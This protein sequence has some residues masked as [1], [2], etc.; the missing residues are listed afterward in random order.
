MMNLSE[1]A[2]GI[3]KTMNQGMKFKT[4]TCPCCLHPWRIFCGHRPLSD[5]ARIIS[6]CHGHLATKEFR[7]LTI[8]LDTFMYS[9][10]LYDF[11][12]NHL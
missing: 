1:I 7:T 6:A 10:V 4:S 3:V 5:A 11:P 9:I 2:H 8:T 12:N